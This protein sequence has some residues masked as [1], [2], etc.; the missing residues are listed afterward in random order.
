VA[1]QIIFFARRFKRARV[2]IAYI[3]EF[4][5]GIRPY[6][7]GFVTEDRFEMACGYPAA[8]DE[9]EF[10]LSVP[11]YLSQFKVPFLTAPQPQKAKAAWSVIY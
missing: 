2:Y 7:A 8:A 11:D 4:G 3:H 1:A 9:S 5:V 10:Y 6:A